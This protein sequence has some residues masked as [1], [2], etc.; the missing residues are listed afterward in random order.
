MSS[1]EPKPG[2]KLAAQRA[3]TRE[4]LIEATKKLLP[5]HG[6]HRLSLDMIA[7]EVGVTKGAIYGNFESKDALLVAALAS[8]P[9][10]DS[11]SFVWPTDRSGS[12]RERMRRLGRA[13]LGG[14]QAASPVGRA[15]FL[16]YALTHDDMRA[17]LQELNAMGPTRM[18]E[19]VLELFTPE[20][21][22][23]P[24]ES[25]ALMLNSLIP[26]LMYARAL[27]PRPIADE[28]I[29]A[30]FE[31]FAGAEDAGTPRKR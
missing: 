13:V 6:F 30:I 7:A 15:E 4:R 18:K 16:L 20:E 11:L 25:F 12:V 9:D 14:S 29:L 31:G 24:V 28:E 3:R 23:M 19:R 27:Q 5:V 21:L 26:G 22:P 17:R 2:S 1:A 8:Q 10:E